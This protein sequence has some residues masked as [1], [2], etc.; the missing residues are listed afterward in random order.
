VCAS[1]EIDSCPMEGFVNDEYDQILNLKSQN[2]KSALILPVGYRA[3]DDQFSSF[4]KVR[5]NINDI[6]LDFN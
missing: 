3:N 4:K 2:L 1:L 6:T 5:K